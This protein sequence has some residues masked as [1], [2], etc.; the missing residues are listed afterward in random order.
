MTEEQAE[1]VRLLAAATVGILAAGLMLL[2]SWPPPRPEDLGE[3]RKMFAA[4]KQR[5]EWSLEI[6][7]ENCPA[8][9]LDETEGNDDG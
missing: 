1:K 9:R 5:M 8:E 7:N 6:L 2:V 4:A 3:L